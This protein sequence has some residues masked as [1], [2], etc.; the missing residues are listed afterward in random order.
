VGLFLIGML[1]GKLRNRYGTAAP[2]IT[3]AVFNA[4]VV[5]AQSAN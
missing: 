3:H 5:L 4:V 1:L 2:I